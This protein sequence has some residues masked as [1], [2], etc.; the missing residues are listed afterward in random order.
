M[1][2]QP[3]RW[4]GLFL[5]TNVMKLNQILNALTWTSSGAASAWISLRWCRSFQLVSMPNLIICSC[6]RICFWVILELQDLD[7]VTYKVQFTIF[8]TSMLHASGKLW[9]WQRRFNAWN[10]CFIVCT[11]TNPVTAMQVAKVYSFV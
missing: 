2:N 8:Y 5:S 3:N 10:S 6:N 9:N 1:C 11:A 7:K 4:S